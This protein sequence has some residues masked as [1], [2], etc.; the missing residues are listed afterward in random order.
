MGV[1]D[2]QSRRWGFGGVGVSSILV[3]IYFNCVADC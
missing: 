1:G 3:G 2:E